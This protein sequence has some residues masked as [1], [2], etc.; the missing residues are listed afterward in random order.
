MCLVIYAALIGLLLLYSVL[1]LE[2][3]VLAV[4]SPG[5]PL[6]GVAQGW[7]I[8]VETWP[9]F[10]LVMMVASAGIFLCCNNEAELNPRLRHDL[11]A[12]EE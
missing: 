12:N 5:Q 8:V 1:L 6:M 9:V 2:G 3:Y 7:A 11:Q 4:N 10:L